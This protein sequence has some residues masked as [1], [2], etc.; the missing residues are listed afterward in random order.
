[1]AA[2]YG[3]GNIAHGGRLEKLLLRMQVWVGDLG[4]VGGRCSRRLNGSTVFCSL[5][6]FY[7]YVKN[8]LAHYRLPPILDHYIYPKIVAA[9]CIRDVNSP[10]H[11]SNQ[12]NHL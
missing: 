2:S 9:G 1:M 5:L 8:I 4:V 7:D 6:V 10:P 12:V 3:E 11:L